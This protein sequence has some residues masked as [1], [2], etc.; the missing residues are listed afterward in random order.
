MFFQHIHQM[1][2]ASYIFLQPSATGW[3][4]LPFSMQKVSPTLRGRKDAALTP[5]AGLWTLSHLS[6]CER[7]SLAATIQELLPYEWMLFIFWPQFQLSSNNNGWYVIVLIRSWK[8]IWLE[9]KWYQRIKNNKE[10]NRR[11]IIGSRGVLLK[12]KGVHDM[13]G[14]GGE[15]RGMK[16]ELK[17]L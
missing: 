12:G 17:M 10:Q 9:W 7:V 4:W 15:T 14:R 2:F 16:R 1:S 8:L 13:E 3:L 11:C 6:Y 5:V